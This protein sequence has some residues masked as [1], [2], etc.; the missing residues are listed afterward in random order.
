MTSVWP[1]GFLDPTD[2]AARTGIP[3][4]ANGSRRLYRK[5]EPPAQSAVTAIAV[6][7]IALIRLKGEDR[8]WRV[9]L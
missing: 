6:L 9:Q 2:M 7:I 4:S 1:G 8:P 5:G 3:R